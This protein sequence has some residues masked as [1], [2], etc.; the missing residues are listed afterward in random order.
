MLA[1][2]RTCISSAPNTIFPTRTY[3]ESDTHELVS[4]GLTS[5]TLGHR[6]DDAARQHRCSPTAVV[7]ASVVRVVG[8]LTATPY[9]NI[10]LV[11]GNRSGAKKNGVLQAATVSITAPLRTARENKDRMFDARQAL[12]DALRYGNV[13]GSDV[14]RV[15]EEEAERRSFQPSVEVTLN[16]LGLNDSDSLPLRREAD[17]VRRPIDAGS[18]WLRLT[19]TESSTGTSLW[20]DFS[21]LQISDDEAMRF[22]ESMEDLQGDHRP[23]NDAFDPGDEVQGLEARKAWVSRARLRRSLL[24]LPGVVRVEFVD[25]DTR[26]DDVRVRLFGDGCHLPPTQSQLRDPDGSIPCTSPR[27]LSSWSASWTR[28]A[29]DPNRAAG[30]THAWSRSSGNIWQTLTSSETSSPRAATFFSWHRSFTECGERD[31][32]P[33]THRCSNGG[34]WEKPWRL[35]RSSCAGNPLRER[36]GHSGCAPTA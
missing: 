33:R 10:N 31:T 5:S 26:A 30:W 17:V 24:S 36:G 25:P 14:R 23:A 6:I 1:Y 32:G 15:F 35:F 34:R 18:P 21:P 12:F 8:E 7:M 9:L 19:C 2:W 16:F 13:P 27:P 11:V 29:A 28:C 3:S 22:L 4:A 20:V